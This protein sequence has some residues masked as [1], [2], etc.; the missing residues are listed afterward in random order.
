MYT[1]LTLKWV[2]AE[3]NKSNKSSKPVAIGF[4][5]PLDSFFSADTITGQV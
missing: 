5:D 4:D 3:K 2:S 1:P